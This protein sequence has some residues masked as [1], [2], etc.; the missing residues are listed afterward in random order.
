MM[1][2]V[3]FV[4]NIALQPGSADSFVGAWQ[5]HLAAVRGEEGC[6]Q[7]DLLRSTS[8]ADHV[9][10]LEHWASLESFHEHLARERA[11]DDGPGV[12]STN[13]LV[14]NVDVEVYEHQ[15]ADLGSLPDS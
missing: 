5:D 6:L 15:P 13:E 1:P 7:Y 10:M 2:G 9:V 14:V 3:R 11:Q 12:A 4:A 8:V